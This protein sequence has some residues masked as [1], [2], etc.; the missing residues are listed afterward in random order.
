MNE[1]RPL[2]SSG[3]HLQH[4][5]DDNGEALCG[6]K[7]GGNTRMGCNRAGWYGISPNSFRVYDRC[8]KCQKKALD[9]PLAPEVWKTMPCQVCRKPTRMLGTKLC[10]G[11]WE[12][13]SRMGPE[14]EAVRWH[15]CKKFRVLATDTDGDEMVYEICAPSERDAQLIAH[16]MAGGLANEVYFEGLYDAR[17]AQEETTVLDG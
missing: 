12:I 1:L 16:L 7:P 10:D 15:F 9:H 11:C 4:L 5:V 8:E 2:R 6:Y 14:M 3:G 13:K 17:K